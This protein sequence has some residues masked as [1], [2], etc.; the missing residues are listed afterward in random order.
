MASPLEVK[1]WSAISLW[2]CITASTPRTLQH[3]S[4]L[5]RLVRCVTGRAR[6]IG[7]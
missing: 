5:G 2:K 3:M 4:L 6:R 1:K 7:E